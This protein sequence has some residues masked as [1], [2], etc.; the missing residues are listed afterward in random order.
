MSVAPVNCWTCKQ[1]KVGC[2][3]TLPT[4]LNCKKGKRE[5]QGYG[6][7]LAWP[8]KQ[9]GRR[10]QKRY[11]VRDQSAQERYLYRR[12]GNLIFL[13]TLI[14]DLDGSKLCMQDLIRGNSIKVSSQVPTPLYPYAINEQ[15]GMLLQ[16]YDL[17]IA[18][19]TTTIDDESNGFRLALLPMAL[20]S[21]DLSACSILY[22]TLA[23]AC[24]HL[25]RP[26]EA[27]KH[28]TRAIRDL[29]SSLANTSIHTMDSVTKTRH[30]AA[31]MMLCVYG[32]FDESDTAWYTHLAGA[33]SVYDIIPEAVK[34]DVSFEFLEPWFQY[35]YIFSQYTYPPVRNVYQITLPDKDP[36]TS[37]II[38][39]LGCSTEVLNLIGVTE[40]ED[41]IRIL[42]LMEASGSRRRIGNYSIIVGLVKAVWKRQDLL[43]DDKAKKQVDWRDLVQDG[44][45]MPSFI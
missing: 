38:G 36:K 8:D 21:C 25:G 1:R 28:K 30:F 22:T 5:C 6:L 2:D 42:D 23:V 19:I 37:T 14:E 33:K 32:V 13:N 27:L 35:H 20:S 40:D 24:Y 26:Q 43:N 7:R 17:K 11:V 4:C 31:S 34:S 15:D 18:R 9:D 44:G 29:S 45:Y 16:H 10:K 41:R 3:R 39:V 12:D